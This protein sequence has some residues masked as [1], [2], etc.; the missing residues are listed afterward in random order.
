MIDTQKHNSHVIGMMY[1]LKRE[2]FL[3]C[4]LQI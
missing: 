4:D 2:E 1:N 3:L